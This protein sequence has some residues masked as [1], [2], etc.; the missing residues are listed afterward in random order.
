M[1]DYLHGDVAVA[2]FSPM[3]DIIGVFNTRLAVQYHV[4]QYMSGFGHI[5]LSLSLYACV[6]ALTAMGYD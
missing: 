5:M 2:K 1:V 3:L 6:K 4:D